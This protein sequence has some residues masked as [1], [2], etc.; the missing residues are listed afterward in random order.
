MESELFGH[1]QGAFTGASDRHIGYFERAQGGTVFLDEAGNLSP[2]AQAKLLHFLQDRV[3]TRVGGRETIELDVRVIVASNVPLRELVLKNLFRED[4]FFR[5]DVVTLALPTLAE[6]VDDLPE[7]CNHFLELFSQRHNKNIKTLSPTAFRKIAGYTWPG[8][9]RELRN[10]IERA[11]LFCRSDTIGQEDIAF[12]LKPGV[13]KTGKR[14]PYRHGDIDMEQ[15]KQV[16][17]ET[18]GNLKE[19]AC[20]LDIPRRTLYYKI[21]KS[22]MSADQLRQYWRTS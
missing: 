4:L 17:W 12:S 15:V 9:I 20:A 14:G 13:G 6:R 11:V 3:I 1:E 18:K 10:T 2:E 22:G 21:K 7:L 5:I 19:A 16:L 8:N